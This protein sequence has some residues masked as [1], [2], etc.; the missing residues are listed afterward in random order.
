MYEPCRKLVGKNFDR[1]MELKAPIKVVF[2]YTE[3]EG[4][5]QICGEMLRGF[6]DIAEKLYREDVIA[7]GYFDIFKNDHPRITS[8]ILPYFLV[9]K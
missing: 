7:F 9:F 2:L 4:V 8:E 6:A 1:F 3:Q 5:C